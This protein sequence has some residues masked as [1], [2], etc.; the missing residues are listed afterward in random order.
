MQHIIGIE[1]FSLFL[2]NLQRSRGL[3]PNCWIIPWKIVYWPSRDLLLLA[4]GPPL[5]RIVLN[6]QKWRTM[7]Q[8]AY[9]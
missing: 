5:S 3:T 4:A 1:F 9:D 2:Y 7:Q 8:L 6:F